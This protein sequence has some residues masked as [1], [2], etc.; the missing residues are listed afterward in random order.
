MT[1][2]DDSLYKLLVTDKK[3]KKGKKEK[4]SKQKGD[5]TPPVAEK[6]GKKKSGGRSALS[7]IV[8]GSLIPIT[9]VPV[10]DLPAG[11]FEITLEAIGTENGITTMVLLTDGY[12]DVEDGLILL[13]LKPGPSLPIPRATESMSIVTGFTSSVR[14]RTLK[15]THNKRASLVLIYTDEAGLKKLVIHS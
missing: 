1:R 8:T 9:A 4:K 2:F 7:N 11:E 15:G 5:G 14:Q 6:L 12:Q 13:S 3:E 10:P